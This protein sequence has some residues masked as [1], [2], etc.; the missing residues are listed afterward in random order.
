MVATSEGTEFWLCFQRN[1]T[2]GERDEKTG[3]LRKQDVIDLQLFIAA[4]EDCYV[5][6]SIDGLLFKRE[7][8]LRA[9]T[10]QNLK[11]DSAAQ[12]RSSEKPER[13]AIHVKATKPVGVYGLNHRFMTT[14]TYLGLP[15]SALGYEYRIMSYEKL[16]DDP[17]LLSQF[18]VI[19][20]EDS[21]QVTINPTTQTLGGKLKGIPYSFT[22]RKGDVYNVIAAPGRRFGKAD[23]TGTLV[24]SNKKIAVFGSHIGAYI[25]NN[26]KKGYNHL[27]EQMPP[28]LFWGRH[29]YVGMLAG[30]TRSVYRVLAAET[31][32]KVYEN[33]E[34]V[35]T[36]NAGEY[37][38]ESN[39]TKNVQISADKR[40]LV[41]QYSIGFQNG[42]GEQL[43]DSI[44]DPMML[45]LTPTNQFLKKY[46]IA[47]PTRG[48]WNH[49]FNLV[50]PR[51]GVSSMK[52]NGKSIKPDQFKPF[53]NSRYMFAQIDVPYGTHVV[54]GSEPFGLYSY[55]FG[56]D[57]DNYDAY[58]NMGG[59]SFVEYQLLRDTLPPLADAQPERV[60]AKL[61]F[62]EDRDIDRGL[63]FVKVLES[64]SMNISEAQFERGAPQAFA[65]A[66]PTDPYKNGSALIELT[67][68]VGNSSLYT[69]CYTTDGAS[70]G[71]V[72]V[73]EG[74]A[75][76]CPLP[77]SWFA[78]VY[79][80]VSLT[81]HLANFGSAGLLQTS[82]TFGNTFGTLLALTGG[83]ALVGRK[84]TSSLSLSLRLGVERFPGS[85]EAPDTTISF[86]R[87]SLTNWQLT[88]F[89]QASVLS[90]NA[91]YLA[92]TLAAEWYVTNNIYGILGFKG[93]F[94]LTNSVEYKRRILTPSSVRYS[95]GGREEVKADGAF[96]SLQ[97][98][99]P[100][101]VLG[102]GFSVPFMRTLSV[103]AEVLYSAPL[104]SVLSDGEWLISQIQ[105]Q[106]GL[107][108]RL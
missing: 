40:I 16:R 106:L 33:G 28:V 64:N 32:T 20:T 41:A 43:R 90:L 94:A 91:L 75:Q 5:T 83:Q 103:G 39:L 12:I 50:V 86:V 78:G 46:R 92:T 70:I 36:L 95:S 17:L 7:L 105:L 87:D 2:D 26:D 48:Q 85:I 44:G 63:A 54:E 67:D 13:L 51:E 6:V 8:R 25:P 57:E 100:S 69:V 82:G 98:F 49:Y 81:N 101:A 1:A 60:G 47:T 72:S 108:L 73:V 66:Y 104:G 21:T 107:R 61:L 62:H 31:N 22:L 19:A 59:Q 97:S 77:S 84:M 3:Q 65:L 79:G 34:L 45:L 4:S 52:L 74:R 55:G 35:A 93:A 42:Q 96:S 102:A 29:Y 68:V 38:E 15:V 10:V 76:A 18:A 24:Q 71:L 56:Y 14:D 88:P 58:G 80:K 99:V 30:C 53:A 9:G 23:L 37:Y 89:Q 27:V 11:I